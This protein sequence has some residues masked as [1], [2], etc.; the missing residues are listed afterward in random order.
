MKNKSDLLEI[1]A[2]KSYKKIDL[3][4]LKSDKFGL[5]PYMSKLD[6]NDA[7]TKLAIRTKMTKTKSNYK[8]DPSNKNSL[9]MCDDCQSVDSQEH[10]LWCPAYG[11]LREDK[12]LDD[13]RHL[14]RYFQQVLRLRDK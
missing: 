1:M 11:H 2:R 12:D 7:R 6:L 14:T 4:E 8:N 5:K 13:D 3:E 10:I 9:W